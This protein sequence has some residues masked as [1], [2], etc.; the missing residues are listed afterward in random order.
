MANRIYF[1]SVVAVA[2]IA[3]TGVYPERVEGVG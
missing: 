3:V 2:E 1:I